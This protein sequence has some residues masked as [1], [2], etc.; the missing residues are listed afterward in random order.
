MDCNWTEKISQLVDGELPAEE[1]GAVER[2]AA[3]CPACRLARE[4]FML[5]RQQL[6]SYRAE[7]N[8]PAERRAL[9]KILGAASGASGTSVG[10]RERAASVFAL[11]RLSPALTAAAAMIA[12]AVL[13][14]LVLLRGGKNVEV[15]DKSEPATEKN[16]NANAVPATAVSPE[17]PNV[18]R[19]GGGSERVENAAKDRTTNGDE[20]RAE[21]AGGVGVQTAS[22]GGSR[23]ARSKR[24]GASGASQLALTTPKQVRRLKLPLT[25]EIAIDSAELIES[26]LAAL[27]TKVEPADSGTARHVEQAQ[28]LLRSFRNARAG[29]DGPATAEIAYEKRR[30]KE[31]LYRNI[32]LRREAASRGNVEVESLLS[33]LEPILI[34]IANLPDK[35]ARDE[36][37]SITERMRKKNI[38]AML[39][40]AD[41]SR[42]Y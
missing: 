19:G 32:L 30:S 36:V 15:A 38:V 29:A 8:P 9:R 25:P 22:T 20:R 28:V 39:Q 6:V 21:A 5:L 11:P 14:G 16:V 7:S 34:D 23:R 42:I 37:R 24:A 40:V 27:S 12:V 33:N 10:W 41:A 4:E 31:L 2:H 1:A 26:Q 3:D 13:I 18:A 17:A 35:P